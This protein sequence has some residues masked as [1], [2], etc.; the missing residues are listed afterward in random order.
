MSPQK[1]HRRPEFWA[2]I[3]ISIFG[4][5]Q[6]LGKYELTPQ[7]V[8]ERYW[9][10]LFIAAGIFQHAS[11]RYRDTAATLLLILTGVSLLVIRLDW[12]SVEKLRPWLPEGILEWLDSIGQ[13]MTWIITTTII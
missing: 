10:T 3:I 6:I 8:F 12:L 4:I 2:A 11:N 5:F 13:S 9:P 7:I 1:W